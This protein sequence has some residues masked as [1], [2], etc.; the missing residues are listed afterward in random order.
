LARKK[1]RRADVSRRME[2]L[3]GPDE[4]PA[5]GPKP[6]LTLDRI[7]QKATEIADKDGLSAVTMQVVAARLGVTSMALYR[8][9]AS[10]SELID[11]MV[12][13]A[14]GSP[15]EMDAALDWRTKLATWARANLAIYQRHPWVLDAIIACPPFGPN[16]LA[17]FESALDAL[18]GIDVSTAELMAITAM[19][20]DHVRGAAHL[21]LTLA[22]TP[23]FAKWYALAVQRA[24]ADGR[25]PRLAQLVAAGAFADSGD[26]TWNPFE[27]GL[28]RVL[29]GIETFIRARTT[30]SKRGRVG[31]RKARGA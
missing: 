10:K 5:R 4:R 20:D 23:Q 21:L 28:E 25:Y 31:R 22:A 15:P 12:E 30:R 2:L 17:W 26:A 27:F 16:Q 9:V 24:S 29:D 8:Y 1:V 6:A 18:S 19:V 13:A 3:W 11:A 7:V 14:L